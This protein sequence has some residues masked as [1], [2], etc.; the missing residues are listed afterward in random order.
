MTTFTNQKYPGPCNLCGE[1][2]SLGPLYD[3]VF[4]FGGLLDHTVAGGYNST[5]GN[6]WGALDDMTQYTF[7][8][9]EFCLDWLFTQFKIPVKVFCTIDGKEE[10]Y[11]PAWNRVASDELRV[12]KEDFFEEAARRSCLREK[13]KGQ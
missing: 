5:P 11:H 9:C 3:D 7:S 6:G 13:R 10:P 8:L 4:D 1:T 2:C 12:R